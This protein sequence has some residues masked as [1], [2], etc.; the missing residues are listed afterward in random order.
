MVFNWSGYSS[1]LSP[2]DAINITV[3][4]LKMANQNNEKF[5][6]NFDGKT[7]LIN[8]SNAAGLQLVGKPKL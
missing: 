5:T 2:L 6:V 8:I 1:A 7:R 3:K 4:Q